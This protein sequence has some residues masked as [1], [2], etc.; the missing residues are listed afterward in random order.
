MANP[1]HRSLEALNP[2]ANLMTAF[3]KTG[4]DKQRLT[5]FYVEIE[6]L[7][8]RYFAY[9]KEDGQV[10][11]GNRSEVQAFL[12]KCYEKKEYGYE[13]Q[14]TNAL[15]TLE[16]HQRAEVIGLELIRTLAKGDKP[17]ACR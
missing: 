17:T 8:V 9:T 10:T 14:L 6:P 11:I 5:L 3:F 15:L 1:L 13:E 16:Q 7:K 2:R 4:D 12:A